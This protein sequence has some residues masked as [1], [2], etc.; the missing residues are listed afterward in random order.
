MALAIPMW[1]LDSALKLVRQIQ[2]TLHLVGWHVA[3]GGGVLNNNESRKDLDLYFFPFDSLPAPSLLPQLQKR[4]GIGQPI[5]D[6]DAEYP[7]ARWCE[8]R[9]KFFLPTGQRIDVFIAQRGVDGKTD[10]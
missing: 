9:W 4:W 2:P 7:E 8:T 6:G 3:L 10:R 5:A 1:T